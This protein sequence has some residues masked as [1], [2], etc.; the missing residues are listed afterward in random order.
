MASARIV[1][2]AVVFGVDG[3]G[4]NDGALVAELL[5][6]HVVTRRKIDVVARIAATGG[7]HVLGVER[8]LERKHDPVHR[9]FFEIGIAAVLSV[10]RGR[11]LKRVGQ[12]TKI[13]AYWRR[14]LRQRAERRMPVEIATAGDGPLAA[15]VEGRQRVHLT[16]I[17]L[18]DGHAEL[19]NDVGIRG[20]RL[21]AAEFERRAFVSVEIGQQRRRF[22]GFRCEM[23][24]CTT[25]HRTLDVRNRGTVFG[26]QKIG[27]AIECANAREVVAH[28]ADA[29]RLAGLDRRMQFVDGCFFETKWLFRRAERL[30]HGG[31]LRQYRQRIKAPP[32][33]GHPA[34]LG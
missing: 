6:Q 12:M 17:R 31:S 34:T 10:K 18:A 2:P 9:H 3:L 28:N 4:E 11:V 13:F 21:H 27:R 32:P 24:R 29:G 5:D 19:L 25:A 16:G 8:V 7:P 14:A 33:A 20:C 30:V 26:N 1:R 22:H 23:Q 15:N